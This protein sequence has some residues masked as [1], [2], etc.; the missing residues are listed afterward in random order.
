MKSSHRFFLTVILSMTHLASFS[1][2]RIYVTERGIDVFFDDQPEQTKVDIQYSRD[3]LHW[4][5]KGETLVELP[6]GGRVF[7]D[8]LGGGSK[9]YRL[10]QT[11]HFTKPVLI[12]LLDFSD[13]QFP[14]N[15][16]NPERSNE[17]SWAQMMFGLEQGEGNHYWNEVSNGIFQM[18]AASESYGIPN[19]GVIHVR[20]EEAAP[21]VDRHDVKAWIPEALDKVSP[22]MDLSSYDVNSDAKI[23]NQELSILFVVNLPY[24]RISG[25]GAEANILINHDVDGV[26]IEKFTRTLS[27][28]S[29]IGVNIHELGHHIF[30]LDHGQD[31]SGTTMMGTGAYN[32]DPTITK[33]TN[34]YSKWGTRPTH[35]S[36]DSK[37][38]AGFVEP[39]TVSASLNQV[40][41]YSA[42][43]P[44]YNVVRLPSI[45]GYVLIENRTKE[46]Y[47]SSL[48][49]A[50]GHSGGLIATK[51]VE[52]RRLLRTDPDVM[53]YDFSSY[54]RFK[55]YQ[56]EFTIGGYR[57]YN[58]SDP[59][60]KMTF[61]VEKLNITPAIVDYRY[62]YWIPDP[63]RAGYRMLNFLP[64]DTAE[65]D[66]NTYS[67]SESPA[68]RYYTINLK[69]IYNTGDI[70]TV[71]HLA[72][73]QSS[74]PYL[75]LLK[76]PVNN[77]TDAIIQFHFDA[78]QP[79]VDR[80]TLSVQHEDYRHDIV[81]TNLPDVTSP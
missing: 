48:P 47:D 43:S 26:R 66:F 5:P 44:H 36:A 20:L 67:L 14:A 45:D 51:V 32:E 15:V 49:F 40:P 46:G 2:G 34:T 8:T 17:D 9:F 28:Y 25:A 23:S 69:A 80:A 58:I 76:A 7:S 10:K 60:E 81:I 42:V 71:N 50:E 75:N 12:V 65:I 57:I 73:W 13:T 64:Q 37:I 22:Y 39:M 3:L 30:N 6:D 59:G 21:T 70:I 68:G 38:R 33:F 27:D 24:S 74:D 55:D 77:G 4:L 18:Q 52:F 78:N 1:M 19:N 16:V 61:D 63:N 11:P 79:Y 54:Y 35:L 72:D 31:A 41:L 29:S 56:D 53:N 62:D